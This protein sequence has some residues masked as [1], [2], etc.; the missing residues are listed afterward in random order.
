MYLYMCWCMYAC[1]YFLFPRVQRA[2][3]EAF[4]ENKHLAQLPTLLPSNFYFQ[5]TQV[6]LLPYMEK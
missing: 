4:C 5:Y 2:K 3:N 6:T 1:A